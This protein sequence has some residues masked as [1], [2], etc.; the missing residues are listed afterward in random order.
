[1]AKTIVINLDRQVLI[2][3]E[4]KDI[5]FEFDC[6]TGDSTHPTPLG[7]WYVRRKH[8]KYTSHKYKVPMNFAMFFTDTGEAIHEGVAVGLLSDLKYLNFFGTGTV[9]GSHGCVRLSSDDAEK[10]FKWTPLQT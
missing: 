6:V 2:A 4:D 9:I 5:R 10:L 7:K 1:M 3:Y 8:Q